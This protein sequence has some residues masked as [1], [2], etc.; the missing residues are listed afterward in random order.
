MTNESQLLLLIW[1]A[2]RDNVKADK[3]LE[4]ASQIV[5]AFEDAGFD[6]GDLGEAAEE[7]R[8]IDQAYREL[9][10]GEEEAVYEDDADDFGYDDYEE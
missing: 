6:P 4:I 7:D 5:R 8:I 10:I 2:V 9:Y 1:E 3:R